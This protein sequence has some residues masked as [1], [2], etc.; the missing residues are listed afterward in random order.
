MEIPNNQKSQ[1]D[2]KVGLIECADY[3]VSQEPT[4]GTSKSGVSE[5]LGKRK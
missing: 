2:L 3:L 4:N 1:L 5:Y